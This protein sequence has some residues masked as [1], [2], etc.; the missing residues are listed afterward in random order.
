MSKGKPLELTVEEIQLNRIWLREKG[1][2]NNRKIILPKRTS[3]INAFRVEPVNYRNVNPCM[4][5]ESLLKTHVSKSSQSPEILRNP[6]S[7]F[8]LNGQN[9]YDIKFKAKIGKNENDTLT[10][11]YKDTEKALLY[12]YLK[13]LEYYS[14]GYFVLEVTNVGLKD[15][16]MLKDSNFPEDDNVYDL[17]SVDLIK[18][19]Y[20][21]NTKRWDINIEANTNL[22]INPEIEFKEFIDMAGQM[23][24]YTK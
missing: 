7:I 2:G 3:E 23:F 18:L 12:R 21:P 22:L 4:L 15:A 11:F 1:T 24:K 20:N 6:N 5:I 14:E 13:K 16:E 9:K 17:H 10:E 19:S 8:E